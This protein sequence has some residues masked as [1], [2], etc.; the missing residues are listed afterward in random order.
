MKF[1]SPRSQARAWG[2]ALLPR[3][4]HP[5]GAQPRRGRGTC[6]L[7]PSLGPFPAQDLRLPGPSWQTLA[8][9]G[10]TPAGQ[11]YPLRL[12][13]EPGA[14]GLPLFAG[15]PNYFGKAQAPCLPASRPAPPDVDKTTAWPPRRAPQGTSH[16]PKLPKPGFP[17]AKHCQYN[18][19][20]LCCFSRPAAHSSLCPERTG[21]I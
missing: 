16:L 14:P 1:C 6:S 21:L 11:L 19:P 15:P 8:P 17:K 10:W 2:R 7:A 4:P 20:V 5:G 18:R 13:E 12:L 9:W 3:A